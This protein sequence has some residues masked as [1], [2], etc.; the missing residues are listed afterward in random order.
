MKPGDLVRIQSIAD[1]GEYKSG[2]TGLI[3]A[4]V[5]DLHVLGHLDRRLFEVL[6]DGNLVYLFSYETVVIDETR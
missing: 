2:D 6:V 1:N 4:D 5:T 3:I